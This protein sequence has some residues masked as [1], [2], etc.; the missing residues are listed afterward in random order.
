M[1]F[2]MID[3]IIAGAGPNGLML[4]SELAL[5]GIRPVVCERL[6]EPTTEQRANG[7][8]GQVVRMLDRRGLYE[9]LRGDPPPPQ[10]QPGF[11]FGA[12][13]LDLRGVADNP[14]YTLQV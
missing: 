11:V 13:P 3:V 4:A 9:R 12:L 5:A 6:S 14:L 1:D 8:V 7:L 10:P 2:V